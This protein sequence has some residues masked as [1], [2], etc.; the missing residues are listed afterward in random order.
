MVRERVNFVSVNSFTLAQKPQKKLEDVEDGFCTRSRIHTIL[1]EHNPE[2]TPLR[3]DTIPNPHNPEWTKSR[4]D[5]IPNG[6]NPEWT[7]SRMSSLIFIALI[8][9]FKVKLC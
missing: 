9:K 2:R 6:H 5:K 3:M 4:M 7:R 1:N 8:F